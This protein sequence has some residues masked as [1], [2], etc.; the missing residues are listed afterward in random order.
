MGII[1]LH[2]HSTF[3]DGTLTPKEIVKKAEQSGIS[4]IALTDHDTFNGLDDFLSVKSDKIEKV[5]GIEISV[6]MRDFNFHLVGLFIDYMNEEFAEKINYLKKARID[7][8]RKIVSKLNELGFGISYEELEKIAGEEIG[9]PHFSELLIRKGYFKDK[10]EVFDKLLKK[11]APAYFD[12]FRYDPLEAINLV[13]KKAKGISILAHPGLLPFKRKEKYKI[14]KELK[15]A[16]LDGLEV[17]YSEHT[18]EEVQ[19]LE[20]VAK[21]L[22]LVVSGGTDFH[23]D[24]KQGISLGVGRGNLKIDYNVYEKL[25]KLWEAKNNDF[26]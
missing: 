11:G 2:I 6:Q 8:N 26:S 17:Y 24:N 20:Q 14:I 4:V 7:R 13:K 15:E 12:K 3:S 23:G 1:D 22:N 9:R 18:A 5:K 16:G 25:K 21:E 10:R 19:F